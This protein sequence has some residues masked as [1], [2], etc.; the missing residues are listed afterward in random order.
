MR[1]CDPLEYRLLSRLSVDGD[2]GCWQWLGHTTKDGY[3][4]I[5]ADGKSRGVHRVMFE[6]EYGPIPD[7]LQIDHLCRNRRCANP[8]HMEA[9]SPAENTRRG[10]A[11]AINRNKTECPQGHPYDAQNTYRFPDGRRACRTCNRDAQRR[12][13]ARIKERAS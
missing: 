4:R 11:G 8:D 2:S 12:Y 6:R 9:V 10:L 5:N 7:G 1:N 3:G 13:V